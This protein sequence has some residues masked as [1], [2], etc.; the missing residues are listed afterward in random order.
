MKRCIPLIFVVMSA[1]L[2]TADDLKPPRPLSGHSSPQLPA[3]IDVEIRCFDIVGDALRS[4]EQRSQRLRP[5]EVVDT[6]FRASDDADNTNIKLIAS[7]RTVEETLPVHALVLENEE[8]FEFIQA[9]QKD[10]S[11]NVSFAPKLTVASGIAAE[12]ADFDDLHRAE[13]NPQVR[14]DSPRWRQDENG[15]RALIRATTLSE[16]MIRTEFRLSQTR[17]VQ[18]SDESSARQR[19]RTTTQFAVDLQPSYSVAVWGIPLRRDE[20]KKPRLLQLTA[21]QSSRRFMRLIIVTPKALGRPVNAEELRR[22][23]YEY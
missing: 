22:K 3:A 8:L 4:F 5:P 23:V 21:G 7:T 9:A 11:S 15:L 17:P 10:E 18:A 14:G 12:I 19:E 16:K 1:G 6:G 2:A 20:P 13:T